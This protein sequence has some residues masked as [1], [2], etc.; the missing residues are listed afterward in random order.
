MQPLQ[1]IEPDFY[2]SYFYDTDATH[3]STTEQELTK[4][5][6]RLYDNGFAATIRP[7]DANHL[8]IFIKLSSDSYIEQAEK[9]L[10]KNYEFGVTSKDDTLSA[11]FRIIHHYLTSSVELGGVGITPAEGIWKNVIDIV[12]VTDAFNDTQLIEEL[13]INFSRTELSTNKIKKVYGIQI[14]LYFEFLKYYI[15]WLAGLSVVG[16]FQYLKKT[17]SFSLTYTFINL[18]WGTLFLAFWHRRE[19]YLTNLW[20]VQN[21]HEIEDHLA[22]LAQINKNFEKKSSYT[23]KSNNGGYRFVKELLFVPIA[24]VFVAVLISYQLGCFFIEIF[25]TDIYDGPGK[26][27]LTLLPTVL[28]VVFVPILTII[29]NAVTD[30]V[31]K[32]EGHDNQYTK[33]N[34]ILVKQFILNFLTS[35]VPLIITSFLYLPFAHLIG[36]HLGDL[37]LTI[38][39]YVGE[40]R[41]YSKYL[42]KLKSQRDFQINQGRLN[43][44]FFYFIVTNQVIQI[45]LKYVLPLIITKVTNII[46]TKV[47]KKPQLK[48]DNDNPYESIWLHNVRASLNLPVYNVDDDFRGLILQYGYLIMFGPVWPLAPLV[49]LIFDVV[50]FKLDNFKLLSGRYF[51]PPLPKR[52]DSTHPWNLAL[53]LLT[54]LG[55]VIS[56]VVTAFYRHGTAPPKSMGQLTFDNASVHL[57]SSVFLVLLMFFSEHGFLI[58]SYVLFKFSNLF[59]S[60][61]EWE[62]DFVENDMKLRRDHYSNHV[63]PTIK[64]RE[65]PD[66]KNFT[67]EGTMDFQPP[68]VVTDA[69]EVNEPEKIPTK[70]LGYTTSS[71]H[72][73]E[74]TVT[75]RSEQARLIAEKEKLLKE[76]QAELKRLEQDHKI[77]AKYD[78][79]STSDANTASVAALE[80]DKEEGDTVIQAKSGPNGEIKP[81][82]ID[83]NKHINDDPFGAS[84]LPPP[85]PNDKSAEVDTNK[86][87]TQDS[88]TAHA[89]AAAPQAGGL[90][91]TA[92]K[93][94]DDKTT[95]VEGADQQKPKPSGSSSAQS[96][97]SNDSL[98]ESRLGTSSKQSGNQGGLKKIVNGAEKEVKSTRSGI[99]KLFK[100]T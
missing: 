51:K 48:V 35:Y 97:A 84:V 85:A 89:A 86:F 71:Q 28:I 74:T 22:E 49:S 14:A 57:S 37:Q 34:S 81:S 52:V 55:S 87:S 16:I 76:R 19:Q 43:A 82:T 77:G 64:V 72:Y 65:C 2:I 38:S 75:S 5:V 56:P 80:R 24:L 1:E 54:W 25:L 17:R 61:V 33:N 21:C 10:M 94:P 47:Q 99:K 3:K 95:S 88:K 27:L 78:K 91:T 63:K 58:L 4:L 11:R 29:Y 41:F 8:L 23:H 13:K 36:P 45:V 67:P 6:D 70:K 68:V 90:T 31:I 98:S 40:N 79:A 53:F 93:G 46:Q 9:D 26:S 30:I 7:G 32:F 15:Y 92:G 50:I 60:Q 66:W 39:S 12:P 42:T 44:Q 20:G 18:I 69:G 62:N 83:S 59:K 96:E 73:T 100:K